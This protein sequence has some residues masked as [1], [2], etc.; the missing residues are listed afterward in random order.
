MKLEVRKVLV[1]YDSSEFSE[2]ALDYAV[3][4]AKSLSKGNP[5]EKNIKI[6]ILHVIQ[7]LPLTKAVLDKMITGCEKKNPS[8]DSCIE[9]IYQEIK[10]LMEEEINEKKLKY[11]LI[12]GVSIES[13]VMYGDP[14]IKIVEY[15]KDNMIDMIII[16]SN[17]LHGFAKIKGLGSVSRKVSENVRCPIVIIR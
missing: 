17:G 5:N 4:L 6:V 9:N 16:G 3:F 14:A 13:S 12:E 7:E 15:A 2:N 10:T 11:K 1:P 8:L